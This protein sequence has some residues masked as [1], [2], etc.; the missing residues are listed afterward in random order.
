[1][2]KGLVMMDK[3]E[4]IYLIRKLESSCKHY[5]KLK[6]ADAIPDRKNYNYDIIRAEGEYK[7][8]RVVCF[9]LKVVDMNQI[10]DLENHMKEQHGKRNCKT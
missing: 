8:L 1:M 9:D 10:N 5:Y 3:E 6:N 4:R 2:E 7:M